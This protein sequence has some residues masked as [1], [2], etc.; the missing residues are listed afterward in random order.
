MEKTILIVDIQPEYSKAFGFKIEDFC[1]FLNNNIE[2]NRVVILWVGTELGG[3]NEYEL[4]DYYI[5][6]GLNED[7]INE[8]EFIEKEYGWLRSCMDVFYDEIVSVLEYM[9]KNDIM[10]TR[11]LTD[12]D[13]KNINEPDIQ[14]YL[15]EHGD[16]MNLPLE[17]M[18][19]LKNLNNI[20]LM[21]GGQY[22]CL[23]EIELM[24]DALNKSYSK[25]QQ[26]IY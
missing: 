2:N 15:E 6:N 3:P 21:G 25:N 9:Y 17:L 8:I 10:D 24:L 18:N 19:E 12:N 1:E 11:D 13:W 23:S 26:F 22:E 20:V 14:S 16:N 5:E 7:L 4:I